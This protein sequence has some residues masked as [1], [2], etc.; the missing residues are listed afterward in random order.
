MARLS[1]AAIVA[2][3][4]A[5]PLLIRASWAEEV[6]C[7]GM[8]TLIDGDNITVKD[9]S[10]EHHMKIEPATKIMFNGKP[11]SAMDLKVGQKVKCVCDERGDTMICTTLAIIREMNR[12]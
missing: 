5:A 8:I 6:K 4:I 2:I 10:E 12:R 7:E 11:G 3:A 1:L 9:I